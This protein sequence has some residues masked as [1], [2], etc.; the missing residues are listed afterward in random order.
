MTRVVLAADFG[1]T[2][3]RAAL[4]SE[5]GTILQRREHQTPQ[6]ATSQSIIGEVV[7]LLA[8]VAELA[9][10][11]P[12][13]VCIATAG[14]ID[15]ERGRV[16]LAPNIPGFRNLVLTTPIA[17]RLNIPAFIENDA[18][19]AALGEFRFGAGRG[20]R[21]LG[22]WEGVA[23]AEYSAQMS[24]RAQDEARDDAQD[25]RGRINLC[26][27][28]QSKRFACRPCYRE[29]CTRWRRQ[30]PHCEPTAQRQSTGR[31]RHR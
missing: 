24:R 29:Y 11:R 5:D 18:S 15:A 21:H 27:R 7:E 13:A 17:Q 3:L 26:R 4:V 31:V 2:H 10:E 23:P 19:A 12:D 1:G 14:L 20:T 8:S 16:I 25:P 28:W 30:R 6:S 9:S 22:I